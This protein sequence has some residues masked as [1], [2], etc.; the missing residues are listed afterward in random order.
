MGSRRSGVT[1]LRHLQLQDQDS[2]PIEIL[3]ITNYYLRSE[4]EINLHLL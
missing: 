2:P 4:R 3:L 1:P